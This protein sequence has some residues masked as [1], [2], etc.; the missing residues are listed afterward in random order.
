MVVLIGFYPWWRI[1]NN[2]SVAKITFGWIPAEG[3]SGAKKKGTDFFHLLLV[4]G[5]LEVDAQRNPD[6]E[7]ESNQDNDPDSDLEYVLPFFTVPGHTR[8]WSRATKTLV[9]INLCPIQRL[10]YYFLGLL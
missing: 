9:V 7:P 8:S 2:V 3:T 10:G 6:S 1:E 5:R 4:K